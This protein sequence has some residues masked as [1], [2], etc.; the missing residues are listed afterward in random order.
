M[1]SPKAI[2]S[3]L[4]EPAALMSRT[5]MVVVL[6][7]VGMVG[8]VVL[9]RLSLLLTSAEIP[10][11]GCSEAGGAASPGAPRAP[12]REPEP[13]AAFRP[14]PECRGVRAP[15]WPPPSG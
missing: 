12:E 1:I 4:Q 2:K 5:G 13:E 9:P 10:G 3:Y 8:V 11:A 14:V 7:V 6:G 15:S